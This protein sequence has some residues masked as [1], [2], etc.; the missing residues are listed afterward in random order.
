M[1]I[2]GLK[3]LVTGGG[4]GIGAA[5]AK[6]AASRGASILVSDVNDA[7]GEAIVEE[8]CQA[9]G[10]AHYQHCDVSDE[11]QVQE[12]MRVAEKSLGGLDI[13]HNNAGI[14]ETMLGEEITLDTMSRSTFER[15]LAINLVGPWMC[16]KYALP[17]LKNSANASIINAGSSGS[18]AGYQY[19]IAYG[20][21]KGGIAMLTKNL[22]VDLAPHG[23]RVNCYCPGTIK[24]KM[25]EDFIAS[26]DDPETLVSPGTLTHLI[27][28]LGE[29]HEVAELVCFL[30]S[31]Q[32][33]FV[34]GVVWLIDGGSLAWRGTIDSLG[35]TGVLGD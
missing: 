19:S 28:R 21:S 9:G 24:T 1:S 15:V 34:N 2:E 30:G 6:L 11:E 8:I 29:T 26:S 12:L 25:V 32:S 10:K 16:S 20:S 4:A 31:A 13:L 27:P 23:I 33:S 35:M 17:M 22:A 3:F 5:T 14:H 7:G 18:I